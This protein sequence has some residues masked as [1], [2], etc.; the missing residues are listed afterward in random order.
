LS[1]ESIQKIFEEEREEDDEGWIDQ[2][3]NSKICNEGREE[4]NCDGP[5]DSKD[6]WEKI[7]LKLEDEW[8]GVDIEQILQ[9]GPSP[10]DYSF[11]AIEAYTLANQ[12]ME[13][14]EDEE[15]SESTMS[16]LDDMWYTGYKESNIQDFEDEDL[17]DNE[18]FKEEMN[19]YIIDGLHV[20]HDDMEGMQKGNKETP[21]LVEIGSPST[22]LD[23]P[24]ITLVEK[25]LRPRYALKSQDIIDIDDVKYSCSTNRINASLNYMP[26]DNNDNVDRLDFVENDDETMFMFEPFNSM[27]KEPLNN[28]ELSALHETYASFVYT[29]TCCYNSH[30]VSI[31]DECVYNKFCK[32]RSCFALGQANDLK[33]A[34]IEKGPILTNH[35]D[36]ARIMKREVMPKELQDKSST[37]PNPAMDVVVFINLR[38]CSEVYK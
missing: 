3:D 27:P 30:V 7:V 15:K 25:A 33:E 24:N 13:A 28:V 2:F 34:H 14:L 6:K 38:A 26:C 4:Y 31:M 22:P 37:S 21:S 36:K 16:V 8:E 9:E 19:A 35:V 23:E 10:L 32:S 29:L 5:S 11:C 1:G 20:P 18:D 12:D 17:V